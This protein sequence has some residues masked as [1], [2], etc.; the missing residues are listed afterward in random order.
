[1][2]FTNRFTLDDHFNEEVEKIM[3]RG[4]SRRDLD[5]LISEYATM[6]GNLIMAN[7]DVFSLK[8]CPIEK[9]TTPNPKSLVMALNNKLS[10]IVGLIQKGRKL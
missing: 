2:Y 10:S 8:D 4:G 6:L 7:P 3:S 9:N 1:L 5:S